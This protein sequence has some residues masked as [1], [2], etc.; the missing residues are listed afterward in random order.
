M[1]NSTLDWIA[2]AGIFLALIGFFML[3]QNR[4]VQGQF[5]A[6]DSPLCTSFHGSVPIIVSKEKLTLCPGTVHQIDYFA[7]Q[8]K[9]TV[10]DCQHSTIQGNGGA[11]F[12]SQTSEP[13]VTIKDCQLEGFDGLY[14]NSKPVNVFVE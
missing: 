5:V 11:L 1:R 6:I 9:E 8:K 2:V 13:S 12:V 10:I 3:I 14:Q 4:T 7:L